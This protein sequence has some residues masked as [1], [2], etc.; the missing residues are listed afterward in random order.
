[1]YEKKLFS[2]EGNWIGTTVTIRNEDGRITRT[3]R[4]KD[5]ASGKRTKEAEFKAW[6][7]QL[8]SDISDGAVTTKSKAQA[9]AAARAEEERKSPTIRQYAENVYLPYIEQYRR[10]NTYATYK[11]AFEKYLLP[12]IGGLKL[13]DARKQDISKCFTAIKRKKDLSDSA[14]SLIRCAIQ[15]MYEYAIE[16]DI[17]EVNPVSKVK[18]EKTR[19][20][21][22]KDH[23]EFFTEKELSHIRELAKEEPI[24]TEALFNL[25]AD[26]GLRVGEACGLQWDDIDLEE[27]SVTVRRTACQGS[28]GA[29]INP[30]KNGKERTVPT[31]SDQTIA[32]LKEL[33]AEQKKEYM[34]LGQPD[35]WN[36]VYVF[37]STGS[38]E[39]LSPVGAKS[40]CYRFGKR[41]GIE[42]IH[43]HM[44]RHSF[45]T[46]LI[47]SGVDPVTVSK[48]LGHSNVSITLNTYS[49]ATEKSFQKA[50]EI[51]QNIRNA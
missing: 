43:M 22:Q 39:P 48:L 29:Y 30:P 27:H 10:E 7:K 35:D 34:L 31:L 45:A 40:I 44:F 2:P 5:I 33:H 6:L 20:K 18:L 36:M 38:V 42:R 17:L 23:V 25:L 11:W 4:P 41:H 21:A 8:E 37:T 9:E 46:H 50:R 14:M 24:R 28:H 47:S 49:H 26:T 15:S 1:M 32:L 51:I 19:N 13:K 3:W 16:N 12:E